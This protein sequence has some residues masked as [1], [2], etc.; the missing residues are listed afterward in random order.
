MVLKLVI[1]FIIFLLIVGLIEQIRRKIT[2]KELDFTE[3]SSKGCAHS[4]ENNFC[5]GAHEV[6]EKGFLKTVSNKEIEYYDDE[7]L[8]AYKGKNSDEYTENEMEEFREILY[9][10]QTDDVK[11]WLRS[12]QL[13]GIKLPGELKNETFK[14]FGK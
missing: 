13:R 4:Q 6:C 11:R 1:G 3:T 14:I 7:E 8:D 2:K 9:T 10:M 5:C 12:L